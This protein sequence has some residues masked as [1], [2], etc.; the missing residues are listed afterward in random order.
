MH[1]FKHDLKNAL[2]EA[3][4]TL[5]NI[6][7]EIEA[8]T[9]Q[10]LKKLLSNVLS[11]EQ[12][13]DMTIDEIKNRLD[14]FRKLYSQV[15]NDVDKADH[16]GIAAALSETFKNEAISGITKI[17][18]PQALFSNDYVL[19]EFVRINTLFGSSIST[20]GIY[21]ARSSNRRA[22]FKPRVYLD[23]ETFNIFKALLSER[24]SNELMQCFNKNDIELSFYVVAGLAS[25]IIGKR[26]VIRIKLQVELEGIYDR[27]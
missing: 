2:A 5:N 4:R 14:E 24:L 6:V 27:R 19:Y 8:E 1:D 21:G 22:S 20:K 16:E 12:T 17:K 26:I 18:K 7:L 15:K 13:E 11:S 10:L 23:N 3:K 25:G 9:D